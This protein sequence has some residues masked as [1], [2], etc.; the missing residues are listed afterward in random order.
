MLTKT[1]D[2]D[3]DN[4]NNVEENI[5]ED[6]LFEQTHTFDDVNNAYDQED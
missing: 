5:Y 4:D 3:N 2:V 1:E 6:N